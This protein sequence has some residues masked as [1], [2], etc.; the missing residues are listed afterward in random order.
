MYR[1]VTVLVFGED[2]STLNEER[3]NSFKVAGLHCKVQSRFAISILDVESCLLLQRVRSIAVG[4]ARS[5]RPMQK[6]SALIIL[7]QTFK[8]VFGV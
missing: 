7:I 4:P 1:I 6:C 8:L 5:G 2:I 3:F